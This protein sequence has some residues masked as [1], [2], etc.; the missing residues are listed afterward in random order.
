M[1]TITRPYSFGFRP[2]RSA[3]DALQVLVD[4]SW[5]G[6][7]WVVET[8][9]AERFSAIPHEKLMQ[10]IEERISDRGVLKLLRVML[11]AGV[12]E[13]GMVRREASGTPQGGPVSPLLCNAYLHR[14]DRA[15]DVGEHGVLVRC[16]DDLVV[17]CRSPEQAEAALSRLTVLLGDLG[18]EPR[19]PR[20]ASCICPKG[21]R[22]WISW[23]PTTGWC[24]GGLPGRRT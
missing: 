17:I 22:G 14:L 19:L 4:E 18:L 16:C 20:P 9:I 3:H 11:R 13:D 1:A 10:V 6:K 2:R 21:D 8:D 24:A 12:L 7:R 23:A 15:W 5:Q